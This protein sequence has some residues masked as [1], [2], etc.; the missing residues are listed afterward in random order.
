MTLKRQCLA[1]TFI[2]EVT[3]YSL[4]ASHELQKHTSENYLKNNTDLLPSHASTERLTTCPS[5]LHTGE[6]GYFFSLSLSPPILL[7]QNAYPTHDKYG[8][9]D[10]FLSHLCI[11]EAPSI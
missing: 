4:L 1:E 7:Y 8:T 10:H 11:S 3:A 5:F 2:I 6:E 9:F